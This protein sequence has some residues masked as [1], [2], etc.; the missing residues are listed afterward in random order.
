MQSERPTH[1]DVI[2]HRE[3]PNSGEDV[4]VRTI[5][6]KDI[7]QI[8]RDLVR[9]WMRDLERTPAEVASFLDL[10]VRDIRS[11]LRTGKCDVCVLER[12]MAVSDMTLEE[13]FEMHPDVVDSPMIDQRLALAK[14]VTTRASISELRIIWEFIQITREM[15]TLRELA[16]TSGAAFIEVAKALGYKKERG[17][18]YLQNIMGADSAED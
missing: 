15:P 4:P 6:V 11:L 12:V 5:K 13:I 9:I 17:K 10:P 16:N 14:L 7:G 18:V 1:Y 3:K 8:L 2:S